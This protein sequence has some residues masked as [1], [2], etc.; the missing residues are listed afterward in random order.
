MANKLTNQS[1]FIKR[2]RDSGYMVNK[3][4][5]KYSDADTRK[6][7]LIIDPEVAS[8]FCTCYMEF[9]EEGQSIHAF[10]IYDGGRFVPARV[11]IQTDSIEV[12][13]QYLNKW[14]ITNKSPK[15]NYETS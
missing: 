4:F 5:D 2:L 11:Q 14:G 6:W 7:T 13:V 10:E 8:L 15:Y 1:Y 3:L 9:D 12:F